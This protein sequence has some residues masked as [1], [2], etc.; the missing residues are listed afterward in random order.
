MNHY[1]QVDFKLRHIIDHF[2]VKLYRLY[3]SKKKAYQRYLSHKILKNKNPTCSIALCTLHNVEFG[4]HVV[5]HEGAVLNTV[6]IGNFSYITP[7]SILYNVDIG[8][9]C[10]IG[11]N[12]QI[13]LPPHPTRKFVSTY[14]GFF[15]I[16]NSGCKFQF[17]DESL[18]DESIP[19]TTLENDI[20]IGS[21]VIVPGG[22]RIG[23]GAIIGAGSVVV[24]DVPPYAIVGGNPARLIRYRFS[25]EKI[26]LLKK[27]AWWD[28]SSDRL[29]KHVNCF[30]NVDLFEKIIEA[31]PKELTGT[32][33]K[34]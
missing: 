15:S 22:I 34:K 27:S 33:L 6:K 1:F 29:K 16:N 32:S 20:W 13:G 18:F 19:Y 11:S 4:R 5:I 25:E 24:K 30:S 8:N 17:T 26:N 2:F 21:N 3:E 28:W 31:K 23:T 14:P 9:F 12:V 10:S 7:N